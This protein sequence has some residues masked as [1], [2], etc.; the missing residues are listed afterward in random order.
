MIGLGSVRTFFLITLNNAAETLR[1][2][3]ARRGEM[4][5]ASVT[6]SKTGVPDG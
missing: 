6:Q 5:D 4:R 3:A 1:R 2:R